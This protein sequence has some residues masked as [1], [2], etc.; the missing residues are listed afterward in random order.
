ML[1]DKKETAEKKIKRVT[2]IGMWVNCSL[3][4]VK[5]IIGSLAGS[6]ALVADGIHSF[7]DLAT[8]LVVLLGVRIGSKRPDSSL[9]KQIFEAA[10]ETFT[11]A[12]LN[13]SDGYR[14]DFDDAWLHVRSSN[15]EPI[16]RIIAEA[17]EQSTARKYIDAILKIRD[18]VSE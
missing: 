12:K 17:Q 16:V 9:A 6:L 14:F 5:I 18:D 10:K 3:S 2:Y 13:S 8:D 11:N 1:P 4:I 15:T 7:S